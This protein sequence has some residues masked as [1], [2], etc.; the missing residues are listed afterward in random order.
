MK[1]TND[2]IKE[3]QAVSSDKRELPLVVLSPNGL[4]FTPKIKMGAESFSS[5]C[6]GNITKMV[7][8][9]E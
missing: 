7:I 3:L 9:Y 8:S 5:L 6:N 4:E 1:T 2:F